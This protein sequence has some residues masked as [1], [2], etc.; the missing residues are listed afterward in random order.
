MRERGFD[1][2]VCVEIVFEVRGARE[3]RIPV[4]CACAQDGLVPLCLNQRQTR[5]CVMGR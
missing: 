4:T 1:G 3:V 2:A 5:T